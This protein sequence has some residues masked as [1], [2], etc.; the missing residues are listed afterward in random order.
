MRKVIYLIA[1][2][3]AVGAVI[4]AGYYFRYRGSSFPGLGGEPEGQPPALTL[5]PLPQETGAPQTP[6]KFTAVSGEGPVKVAGGSVSAYFVYSATSSAVLQTNGMVAR[7][8]QN[9]AEV[10]SSSEIKDI[11]QS[12]F[13]YDGRK[14]MVLF[15]E[16]SAPQG[17]VFDLQTKSWQP[18]ADQ[19]YAFAWAPRDPRL[20]YLVKNDSHFEIRTLDT[21]RA[22]NRPQVL[23]TIAAEDAILSWPSSNQIL[24]AQKPGAKSLGTLIKI[25]LTKK[26]AAPLLAD[27]NGLTAV[28]S[29]FSD[30][31]AVFVSGNVGRGGLLQLLD[32]RGNALH[33]FSFLTLPEKCAFYASVEKN[34]YLICGV[35]ISYD[36]WSRSLLPDAYLKKEIFSRDWIYRVDMKTGK[37]DIV[38][39]GAGDALDAVN[40]KVVG[41]TLYF[42]NRI[43]GS[44]YG[45]AL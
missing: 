30:W 15:G 24:L 29:G 26:T 40:L 5:P 10:L 7:L 35:P 27:R 41:D 11:L 45:L 39:D 33:T 9:G 20:A 19:V 21:S 34:E 23:M 8:D 31:G 6:D 17:S 36:L 13:S 18:L 38:Y 14:L 2:V 28:W 16:R 22:T 1:I 4:A 25:D 44:L 42:Q 43:D 3:A 12:E 37:I 32:G